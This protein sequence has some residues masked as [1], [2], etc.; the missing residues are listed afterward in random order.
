[1]KRELY[2][3]QQILSRWITKHGGAVTQW[4]VQDALEK[5]EYLLARAD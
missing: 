4:E 5:V 1:M 2:E 3:I